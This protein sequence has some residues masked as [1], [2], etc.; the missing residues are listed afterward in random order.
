MVHTKDAFE[1]LKAKST[2]PIAYAPLPFTPLPQPVVRPATTPYRLIVFGYLGPNRR[3]ESVFKAL[4]ELPEREQFRLDVF[5][6][7]LKNRDE[8]QR[9]IRQLRLSRLVSL[10]GFVPEDRLESALASAHL[11]INLRYPTVGEASGS[12]L[13]IWAHALPSL[14]SREG[15]YASLPKDTVAFVRP[16][17]NEV[18]DIQHQL[19]AF[20]KAPEEFAHMGLRGFEKLK[21]DHAPEMYAARI[22]E[23]ALSAREY[24]LQR[25]AE[26]LAKRAGASF[27]E[28]LRPGDLDAPLKHVVGE[29][30]S[31]VKG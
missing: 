20:I 1:A 26:F 14:V 16:D 8:L 9:Q 30:L 22:I 3:L 15:W 7:I 29:A 18:G 24:R 19:R 23:L 12:Q 17:D 13:R 11:A 4:A 31:L 28:W 6:E 25:A 5:G 2:R 21:R 10:R 27:T